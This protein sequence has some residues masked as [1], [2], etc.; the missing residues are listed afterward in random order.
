M[1][2]HSRSL[3]VAAACLHILDPTR[4]VPPGRRWYALAG[5]AAGFLAANELPAVCAAALFFLILAKQNLR[6][7]LLWYTPPVALTLGL[8]LIL[9]F[10]AHG[11]WRP[12]YAHRS[13]GAKLFELDFD[14]EINPGPLPP[15]LRQALEKRGSLSAAISESAVVQQLS[16]NRWAV[17]DPVTQTRLALRP[18]RAQGRVAVH[19][20][21]DWYRYEGTY[22]VPERLT[23]VDQGE[24]SLARYCFHLTVG[25]HGIL[26]LTPIWIYSLWGAGLWLKNGRKDQRAL[27]AVVIAATLICLVFYTAGRPTI[28]RNYGGVNCGFRWMFWFIPWWLLAMLPAVDRLV[29]S[30]DKP[31]RQITFG[32]AIALGLLAISVFSANYPSA[33]PWTHPWIYEYWQ[34]LGWIE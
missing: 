34:H 28:D 19:E 12:A 27:M 8:L 23:G 30:G 9:N 10:A 26:S 13:D 29:R 11:S 16:E 21:D 20:W 1:V 25:H 33:N 14:Q 3:L 24:P 22:W 31:Q 15:E 32:M 4:A 6:A 5:L 18:E 7:T 17:W 2:L